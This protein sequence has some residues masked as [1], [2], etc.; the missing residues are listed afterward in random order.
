MKAV[1]ISAYQA[2]YQDILELFNQ[3]EI[4]GFTYWDEVQGRGHFDGDPH[5]GSHA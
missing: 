2:F 3:L 1:F 5:Y 4:R